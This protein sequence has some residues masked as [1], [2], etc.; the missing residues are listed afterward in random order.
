MKKNMGVADR[1][2][3]VII[4]ATVAVLYLTNIISGTVGMILLILA[5]IILLTSIFRICP[6]YLPFGIKTCAK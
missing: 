1:I 5:G 3:R 6:T 2:I 4:A